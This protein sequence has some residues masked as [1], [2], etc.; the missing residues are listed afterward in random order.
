MWFYIQEALAEY[1]LM[2]ERLLALLT[3]S[4]TGRYPILAQAL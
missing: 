3:T 2:R 4:N 1:Y